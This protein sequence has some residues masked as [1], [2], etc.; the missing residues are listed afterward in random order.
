MGQID[1]LFSYSKIDYLK[2]PTDP[3]VGRY[4][5]KY[6]KYSAIDDRLDDII[7]N[8]KSSIKEAISL[9]LQAAIMQQLTNVAN[10]EL[11]KEIKAKAIDE[12]FK[13][14]FQERVEYRKNGFVILN[15]KSEVIKEINSP[16]QLGLVIFQILNDAIESYEKSSNKEVTAA[17]NFWE[18]AQKDFKNNIVDDYPNGLVETKPEHLHYFNHWLRKKENGD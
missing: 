7:N 1:E 11:T 6:N 8:Q 4:E 15:E 17:E 5:N 13:K 12:V 14:F 10:E 3:Y 9:Y 18:I 16:D 2:E